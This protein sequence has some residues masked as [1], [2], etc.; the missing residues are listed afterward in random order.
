[1]KSIV[2]RSTMGKKACNYLLLTVAF[3]SLF[4][5]YTIIVKKD[6]DDLRCSHLVEKIKS[7]ELSSNTGY[8]SSLVDIKDASKGSLE[9]RPYLNCLDQEDSQL[10][11]TIRKK[12]LIRGNG[13]PYR[14]SKPYQQLYHPFQTEDIRDLVFKDKL[15]NGFFIEA[16]S[17]DAETG[18]VSLYF[19]KEYN[20]TGL[21]IEVNPSDH[22]KG[23]IKNRKA[24]YVNT[25]LGVSDR[26]H[27]SMLDLNPTILGTQWNSM[28]GLTDSSVKVKNG[29]KMQCLP[30]YSIIQAAGSPTVNLLILDIEGAELAVLKTLPWHKVDIEVMTVETDLIGDTGGFTGSQDEIRKFIKSKGY[31]LFKH[32]HNKNFMTGKDNNDLFIREDIV[33]MWNVSD[34]P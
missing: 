9:Y 18:S 24:I 3:I 8:F 21:L 5:C 33:R 7:G 32:R 1:M 31:I 16:G 23:V 17:Y 27:Y 22:K 20:W 34:Y 13:H 25:C 19:E 6:I 29:M 4:C 30:L 14:L 28:A 26:P 15:S 12:Y 11:R 2:L 10:I